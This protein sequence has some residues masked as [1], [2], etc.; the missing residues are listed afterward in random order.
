TATQGLSFACPKLAQS[1][2][3]AAT[4]SPFNHPTN[5]T[6][7][8]S[9]KQRSNSGST[10]TS[11]CGINAPSRTVSQESDET[12]RILAAPQRQREREQTAAIHCDEECGVFAASSLMLSARRK[13]R[14]S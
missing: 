9:T 13:Q 1:P 12:L 3:L 5:R 7:V 4:L 14:R 11:R 8:S 10:P 2:V 6:V